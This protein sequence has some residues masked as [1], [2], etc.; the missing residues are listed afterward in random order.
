MG[1][2]KTSEPIQIKMKMPKPTQEHSTSSKTPID[3]LQD[4]DVHCTFK[5][6]KENQHLDH[7]CIKDQW[8]YPNQIQM[9]NPSQEPQISSEIQIPDLKDMD[10]IAPSKSR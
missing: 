7:A 10:I 1:V 2:S 8:T 6:K 9:P 3:A 4:I 5:I